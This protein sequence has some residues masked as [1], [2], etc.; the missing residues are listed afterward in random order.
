MPASADLE[1]ALTRWDAESYRIDLRYTQPDSDADLLLAPSGP[2]LV[3]F[4]FTALRSLAG[5][6]ATYGTQLAQSL[7]ATEALRTAFAQARR[8]AASHD[9][10]LRVRLFIDAAA[11]EL[12]GLIWETLVDP[13]APGAAVATSERVLFS[14]YLGSQDWRRVRLRPRNELRALVCVPGPTDLAD[15]GLPPVDVAGE[16]ARAQ[17]GLGEIAVT[18]ADAAGSATV[19]AL[20]RALHDDFDVLYLVC[21]GALV[22]D[23]PQLWLA[24]E[25]GRAQVVGGIELVARIAELP[26]VPRLVVLAS[27]ESA[28]T[29]NTAPAPGPASGPVGGPAAGH[30]ALAALGPRLA[31]AGVPAVVAMQ[32]SISMDTVARFMPVFFRELQRDGQ[33]DRAMAAARGAVR[34]RK[35]CWMPLL[36]MRLKSGRIWYVPGFGGARADFEKWPALLDATRTGKCTPILGAGLTDSLLG[37]RRDIAASWAEQYRFPLASYN[38]E[39]LPEVA[40]YLAVNQSPMFPVEG[41]GHYLRE[42]LWRRYGSQLPPELKDAHLPALLS[43]VGE[44]RRRQDAGEPHR[45]LAGLPFPI[46][47]TTNPDNLLADALRAAGKDPQVELCRWN[48]E[49]MTPSIYELDP[50]YRPTAEK[51]LVY[52]LFGQMTDLDSLVLTEDDY[53]DYLIGVTSNKDLIPPAVRRALADSALLFLGFE[54]DGW[55]FRVLFRSIMSQEGSSRRRRYAHVAAQVDPE[56]GRMLEPERARHYL[57]SYFQDADISIYWGTADDFVQ[58]LVRQK[59]KGA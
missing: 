17:A 41:L 23:E 1:I 16:L 42:Q 40:Q 9:A 53:F 7:F 47:I 15:Y 51:P 13:Q 36:L 35:D 28:G 37:Q 20:I 21:H 5:D 10:L 57:E 52:C 49:I 54:L 22:K 18:V 50:N 14:R 39:S 44:Q 34:E 3:R 58:D 55:D 26:G 56:G 48:A 2:Q 38:R 8:D 25:Q 12:H 59:Q 43:A 6:P 45:V 30:A 29:P 33:V 24:D 19:E 31:E 4:D 46:Y 27:C 32:G 11:P